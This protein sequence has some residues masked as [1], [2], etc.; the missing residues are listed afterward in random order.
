MSDLTTTDQPSAI[1]VCNG[2]SPEL[3]QRLTDPNLGWAKG[4]EL[5]RQWEDRSELSAVATALELRAR[6][7]GE[8]FVI[9]ALTPL[10]TLYGVSDKSPGEWRAFWRF[11]INALQDLPREAIERGVADYVAAPDS[12]FFPK[13]GP[14]KALCQKRA[15]T[16]LTAYGRARK[17]LVV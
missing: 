10:V 1:A 4:S 7:A 3:W 14:L 17:A 2:C 16:I 13:P 9:A 8:Q 5:A 11:Y 12:D 6:P 15:E